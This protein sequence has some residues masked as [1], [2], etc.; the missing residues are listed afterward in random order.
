MAASKLARAF[1]PGLVFQ[2][3]LARSLGLASILARM[4]SAPALAFAGILA[5]AI[6]LF[7]RGAAALAGT[8]VLAFRRAA[9]TFLLAG[10]QVRDRRGVPPV[11]TSPY[12]PP[13]RRDGASCCLR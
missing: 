13:Q 2:S 5:L 12:R 9:A 1:V 11:A 8:C 6:V 3:H 10:V 7:G 4:F